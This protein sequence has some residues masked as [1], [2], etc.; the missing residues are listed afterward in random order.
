MYLALML[1]CLS[2]VQH[3]C[4]IVHLTMWFH[5]LLKFRV[6]CTHQVKVNTVLGHTAPPLSVKLVHIIGSGSKD[7]PLIGQVLHGFEILL[8]SFILFLFTSVY[9]SK[10]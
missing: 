6:C 3:S 5:S 4:N 9:I 7:A 10:K 8:F 1:V 2:K